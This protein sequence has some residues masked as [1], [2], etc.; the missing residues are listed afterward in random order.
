MP[1]RFLQAGNQ[2]VSAIVPVDLAGGANNGDW[3]NLKY[4]GRCIAVLFKKAGTGGENPVF[5]LRQAQ[6][7]A[8]TGAKAL[9]FDTI[10]S[11]VGLQTGIAAFTKTQQAEAGTYTDA[12]SGVAEAIIAVE[13]VPSDLDVEGNF[14]HVQL[15][16]PDTGATIGALGCAFYILLEPR[17]GVEPAVSAIA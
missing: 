14:T 12:G 16:I 8:G 13:I 7:A 6:D 3:V 17:F 1:G 9:A 5:T 15:Q 4:F 11:K 2:I 10:F